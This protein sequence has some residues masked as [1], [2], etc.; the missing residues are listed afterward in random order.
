MTPRMSRRGFCASLAAIP[1]ARRL[2]AAPAFRAYSLYWGDLHCHSNLSY[3]EG[4]P[5]EGMKAAREHLDFATITAHAAW[6]DMPEEPGRLG[7]VADYHRK[8]FAKARRRWPEFREMMKRYRKDGEFISF[9]SYEWHSM[10]YGDR[11]VVYRDFDGELVTP[12]TLEEMK[13]RLAGRNAIVIPHHIAYQRGYR[14][15]D[16]DYYTEKLA[17]VVEISSKHGTSETDF[18]PNPMLHDMGPRTIE[19]TAIE[20]LRRGLHFGFIASTDNH[21]GFPGCY[22]EG[23][24]AVYAKALTAE[25]LWEAILDRRTYAATGDRIEV[26]FDVNGEGMGRRRANAAK[27]EISFRVRGEDF[28]DYVDVV[29]NGVTIRRFNGVFPGAV[30]KRKTMRIK[31]RIEWGWGEKQKTVTWDGKVR[32][33]GGRLLRVTPYFRGQLLLAPRQEHEREQKEFTPIHRIF[34][35]TD[36]GFEFRSYTYGNPNTTTP[37]TCSVVVEAEMAL[38]DRV[39]L[40]VNGKKMSYSLDRLL[41]GTRAEFLR[42]WLSEAVQVHR[43]VPA[44]ALELEGTFTDDFAAPAYYYL[45]VRQYNGQWAWSSPVRFV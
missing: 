40:E 3:G 18:A 36:K 29:R 5:E 11:T 43:A 27:K 7:W 30:Q 6:P 41:D 8:G 42:G 23:R 24:L 25:D 9:I 26:A 15:I 33:T 35:R 4:D 34:N 45:R 1:A 37:A 44:R 12:E 32:L 31:F 19:G 39:A 2:R 13:R 21:S 22:G 28:I 17:P 16:W 38:T 14:G 10:K 20:G